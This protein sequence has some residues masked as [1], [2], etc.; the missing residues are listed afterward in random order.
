[1]ETIFYTASTQLSGRNHVTVG[2]FDGVHRGHQYLLSQLVRQAHAVG[3]KA[4][5][6]TFEQD[7]L[8]T[9]APSREPKHL[10]TLSLR[11][12][13][14]S[15]TGIDACVVLPFT[16][17]MAELSAQDFLLQILHRQLGAHL[18]MLGYDNRFGRRGTDNI[19][20]LQSVAKEQGIT[21]VV[22]DDFKSPYGRL[23]SS[24]VRTLI[25]DNRLAEACE[26][27]TRPHTI[28]GTVVSGYQQGRQL[29][30]PTANLVLSD[31]TLLLPPDGVYAV[32]ALIPGE[33]EL[34]CGMMNIGYRPTFGTHEKTLE[35]NLFHFEGNLYDRQLQ[36]MFY[37]RIRDEKHFA[38]EEDLA[39]QLILDKENILQFFEK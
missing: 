11:L 3:E 34:Y 1:M 29:G 39:R 18:V 14:L 31:A 23:S 20:L 21:L 33:D 16:P 32:K 19:E 13:W 12:Q 8:H 38:S 25:A 35:V 17:A 27:L 2:F 28:E 6:V 26:C 15:T 24:L 30:F 36:V 4:V 5:A 7:P 37:Q 10:S 22:C 9:V